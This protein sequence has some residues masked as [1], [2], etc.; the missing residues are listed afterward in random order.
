M[1]NDLSLF[2]LFFIMWITFIYTIIY[3]VRRKGNCIFN[4]N[5]KEMYKKMPENCESFSV[6]LRSFDMP[7]P[8]GLGLPPAMVVRGFYAKLFVYENA[9]LIKFFDKA[10]LVTSSKEISIINDFWGLLS[11]KVGI[12][13]V[14]FRIPANNYD[15]IKK[16]ISEH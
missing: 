12:H 9:M 1:D 8:I 6:R 14:E 10:M 11:I 5:F 7:Q 13:S 3:I 4:L 16:W 15:I 2:T